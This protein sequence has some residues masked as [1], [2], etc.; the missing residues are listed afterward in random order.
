MQE[1]DLTR[2]EIEMIEKYRKIKKNR[3]YRNTRKY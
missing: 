3:Y 1:F 2:E